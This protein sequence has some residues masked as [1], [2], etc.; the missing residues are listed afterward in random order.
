MRGQVALAVAA[1]ILAT[2]LIMLV[3][4]PKRTLGP[5]AAIEDNIIEKRE[6]EHMLR[7]SIE[8]AMYATA[9]VINATKDEDPA[10]AFKSYLN[11]T[12]LPKA[13]AYAMLRG[14]QCSLTR[15]EAAAKSQAGDKYISEIYVEAECRKDGHRQIA[16]VYSK[17]DVHIEHKNL[18]LFGG[19]RAVVSL[20]RGDTPINLINYAAVYQIASDVGL[21]VF[22]ALGNLDPREAIWYFNIT[23]RHEIKVAIPPEFADKSC[24]LVIVA[25]SIGEGAGTVITTKCRAEQ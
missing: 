25:T 7:N 20:T 13:A 22:P 16:F 24:R 5:Q 14:T 11:I 19:V 4:L 21:R 12:F 10:K 3:T 15:V 8:E 17:A 6:I 2:T 18:G 1:I 23:N 9:L